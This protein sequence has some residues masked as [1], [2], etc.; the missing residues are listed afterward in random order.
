MKSAPA[1]LVL[2]V[3]PALVATLGS[4]V[5]AGNQASRPQ[6]K[7]VPIPVKTPISAEEYVALHTLAW[8]PENPR[9]EETLSRLS[10][11]GDG[12][13]LEHLGS[14]DAQ[15]LNPGRTAV[16]QRTLAAVRGRIDREDEEVF[17]GLIRPRLERA[18]LVDLNCHLLEGTLVPWTMRFLRERARSRQALAELERIRTSYVPAASRETLYSS[19]QAR[20][21]LYATRIQEGNVETFPMR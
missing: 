12:F 19:M 11:E 6:A 13:T 8:N 14:L 18:A 7:P 1:F 4:C 20:V 15:T 5:D 2:C 10:E 9:W 21:R 3:V 17:C 16:L